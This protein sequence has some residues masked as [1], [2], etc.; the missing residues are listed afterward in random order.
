[1]TPLYYQNSVYD[2]GAGATVQSDSAMV[3]SD[4][5]PSNDTAAD[6]TWNNSCGGF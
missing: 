5:S 4:N 2:V 6:I 1:V 3:E